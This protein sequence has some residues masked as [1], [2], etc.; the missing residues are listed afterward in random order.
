MFGRHSDTVQVSRKINICF[1]YFRIKVDDLNNSMY[2]GHFFSSCFYTTLAYMHSLFRADSNHKQSLNLSQEETEGCWC[3]MRT[4][5]WPIL[6]SAL[7]PHTA[8]HMILQ[9]LKII[10]RFSSHNKTNKCTYVKSFTY[11]HLLIN[12]FYIRAFVDPLM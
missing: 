3:K 7:P 8:T 2:V 6:C 12:T 5:G 4:L 1:V 9:S 11:V 10:K